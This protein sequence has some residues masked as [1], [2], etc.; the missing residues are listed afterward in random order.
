M[1]QDGSAVLGGGVFFDFKPHGL[2]DHFVEMLLRIV[3][4]RTYVAAEKIARV[5]AGKPRSSARHR[6][7]LGIGV[8]TYTPGSPRLRAGLPILAD[9][10][11]LW[12]R[13]AESIT[14]L[15]RFSGAMKAKLLTG[16]D[17][18]FLTEHWLPKLLPAKPVSSRP[19]LGIILRD[20]PPVAAGAS[21]E[22]IAETLAMLARDYAITGFIFDQH[23]D[24]ETKRLL[25]PYATQIWQPETMTIAA[26]SEQLAMQDVLL[27]SRAHGAICGACLG[28]PSVIV[29]IEPKLA[30][31]AAMLPNASML[32]D[33]ASPE[34]WPSAVARARSI[35]PET[36]AT[37]VANN[38]AASE[39]AFALMRSY[40]A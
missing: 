16:S 9:F 23:T 31:V 18:A 28:V 33:A 1:L 22:K 11:A 6:L 12:V 25:A 14:N 37:D 32:V 39:A 15:K 5:V 7:G 36:I 26:F 3:G 27:T 20:W 4:F 34:H 10:A 24:P 30:H 35:S 21:H 17:L 38:R 13:D 8:G 19:R 40:L 2:R 29:G